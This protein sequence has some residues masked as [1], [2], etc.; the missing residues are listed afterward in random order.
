[1]ANW[2]TAAGGG[3]GNSLLATGGR[4]QLGY[5]L[6]SSGTM[7]AGGNLTGNLQAGRLGSGGGGGSSNY[8]DDIM[9]PTGADYNFDARYIDVIN[10]NSPGKNGGAGYVWI[11]EFG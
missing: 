3:G 10:G 11:R 9:Y 7:I 5:S 6:N 4:G 2:R 1:V 8:D